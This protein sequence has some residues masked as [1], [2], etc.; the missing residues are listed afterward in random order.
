MSLWT[1]WGC[2]D[3]MHILQVPIMQNK[4]M[5]SSEFSILVRQAFEGSKKSLDLWK[6]V[7]PGIPEG[8]DAREGLEKLKV[9]SRE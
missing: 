3:L 9:K 8:E 4:W 6:E 7:E 1:V 2:R 5:Y